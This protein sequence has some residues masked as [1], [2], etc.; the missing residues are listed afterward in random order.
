MRTKIEKLVMICM[1]AFGSF[2]FMM[3]L[4][5][6]NAEAVSEWSIE[7]VDSVGDVGKYNSI[8]ID[9]NNRPRISYF[10]DTNDDLK[11]VRAGPGTEDY[12]ESAWTCCILTAAY[13]SSMEPHVEILRKFRDRFLLSNS[14]GKAFVKLYYTY[15]PAAADFITKHVNLQA[16]IRLSLLPVVG[17][18]RVA[19]KLGLVPTVVL[20]LFFSIGLIRLVIVRKKFRS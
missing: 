10:D 18:S 19:L 20:M 5:S 7:I 17:V 6:H 2:L 12:T 16:M 13:G 8:A 15:S 11:Y 4:I 1:M 3:S 14:V 9:S